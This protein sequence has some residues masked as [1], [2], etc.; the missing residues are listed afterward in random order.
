MLV[1]PDSSRSLSSLLPT[2]TSLLVSRWFPQFQIPTCQPHISALFCIKSS[3]LFLEQP[4]FQK[5]ALVPCL[6]MS[7]ASGPGHERQAAMVPGALR[8]VCVLIGSRCRLGPGC[9]PTGRVSPMLAVSPRQPG[10]AHNPPKVLTPVPN[11]G[12][13]PLYPET[14][15]S[16][17]PGVT[18][19]PAWEGTP[20]C[21]WPILLL[22]C[23]PLAPVS[24]APGQV[25]LGFCRTRYS[26]PSA[27]TSVPAG[28]PAPQPHPQLLP[29]PQGAPMPFLPCSGF[30]DGQGLGIHGLPNAQQ[31]EEAVLCVSY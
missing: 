4:C 21:F 23:Q 8:T 29:P 18:P 1:F 12:L 31:T 10:R 30:W 22:P 5:G 20:F 27:V 2:P 16:A 26:S 24:H 28:P 9:P 25:S 15:C 6:L 13:E 14:L 19:S 11:P 17:C 3:A 7:S